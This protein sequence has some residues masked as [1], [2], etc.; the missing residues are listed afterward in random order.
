[1]RS[2]MARTA[3]RWR[4]RST[5]TRRRLAVHNDGTLPAELLPVLFEPFHA[6]TERRG[7]GGGGGRRS[8]GLGLYICERIVSAH[9]GRIAVEST[10][11]RGTTFRVEL[12][13]QAL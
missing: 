12:P 13:R 11:A 2:S 9:G 5:A 8:L 7:G 4:S 6:V 3:V 1:M 10:P